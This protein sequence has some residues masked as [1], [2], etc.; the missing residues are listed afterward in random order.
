MVRSMLGVSFSLWV[1]G[2]SNEIV[3]NK[4]V[5]MF[6]IKGVFM[7]LMCLLIMVNLNF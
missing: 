2:C 7:V 3:S 5:K 4:S 1:S 6:V